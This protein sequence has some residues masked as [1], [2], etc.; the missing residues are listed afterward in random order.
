MRLH[1]RQVKAEFWTDSELIQHLDIPGRMVY[2]GLI[3]LADD[4]GCLL[5]D[6]FS[7][8]NLLFPADSQM[9]PSRLQEYRDRLVKM[10]KLIPYDINRKCLSID[11]VCQ[12]AAGIGKNLMQRIT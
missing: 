4:S 8:K 6:V 9:K 2:L 11:H 12:V 1:N 3:Q 5:D 7:T 10:G